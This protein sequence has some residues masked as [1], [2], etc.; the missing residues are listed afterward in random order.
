MD[1]TPLVEDVMEITARADLLALTKI[2]IREALLECHAIACFQRDVEHF[3]YSSY[4]YDPSQIAQIPFPPRYRRL[5]GILQLDAEGNGHSDFTKIYTMRN[6]SPQDGCIPQRWFRAIGSGLTVHYSGQPSSISL[7]YLAHP[8]IISTQTEF[9]STSWLLDGPARNAVVYMAA[10]KIFNATGEDTSL[11]TYLA[12][13][14]QAMDSLQ[15]Q[16]ETLPG[17]IATRYEG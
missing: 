16:Y 15:Y 10:A 1:L 11:R 8:Q 5:L 14:T 9:S 17:S 6:P 3:Q 7:S 4:A 13:G 2:A 12:L